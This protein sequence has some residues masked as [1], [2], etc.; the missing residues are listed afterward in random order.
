[1]QH[2]INTLYRLLA[3]DNLRAL[4]AP[5]TAFPLW[6]VTQYDWVQSNGSI[7]QP[8]SRN[9]IE[10]VAVNASVVLPGDPAKND[11][12]RYISSVRM[13]N[14][15]EMED[16]AGKLTAP[17]W[18]EYIFGPIDHDKAAKGK[19]LYTQYCSN[20]HSPEL[21]STQAH[22]EA[23]WRDVL[24]EMTDNGAQFTPAEH[25]TIVQYLSTVFPKK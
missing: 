22:D 16:M 1:M 6:Y 10:S 18:P 24:M 9:I 11:S 7:R 4:D 19:E 17:L 5:V 13:K 14:M 25:D 23:G 15:W 3:N 12:D 8:M 20:C 21:A 2:S